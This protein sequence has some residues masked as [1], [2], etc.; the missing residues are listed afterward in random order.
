MNQDESPSARPLPPGQLYMEARSKREREAVEATDSFILNSGE[1]APRLYAT[2]S[3]AIAGLDCMASCYW[4]CR[5]GDHQIEYLVGR[6]CSSASAARLLFRNAYYDE[7]LSLVRSVGEIVNLLFLF[8]LT[9]TAFS[10]WRSLEDK[11]RRDRYSPVKVRLAIEALGSSVPVDA[12]RYAELSRRSVHVA[13]G[14]SPQRYNPVGIP[15]LGAFFQSPGVLVV[16]NELADCTALLLL[17]GIAHL[18]LTP[19]IRNQLLDTAELLHDNIGNIDARTIDLMLAVTKI[20]N[21]QS[22]PPPP[23]L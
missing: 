11:Q 2:L 19:S 4:G 23:A 22:Y 14:N 9:P 1:K 18:E 17:A 3:D 16:L 6:G 12:D 8:R 20:Q 7:A 10:D 5:G 13:P 15:T 21:G